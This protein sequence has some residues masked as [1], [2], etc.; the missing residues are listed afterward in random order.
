MRSA[1]NHRDTETGE[2]SK[3]LRRRQISAVARSWQ[4]YLIIKILVYC[5][6]RQEEIRNFALWRNPIPSRR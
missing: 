4:T 2:L 3:Y 5:P 6:V 1:Y